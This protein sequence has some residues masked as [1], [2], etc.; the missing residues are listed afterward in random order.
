M[1]KLVGQSE[2][3]IEQAFRVAKACSPCVLLMDEIEKMMG[4]ISSSNSS[5][6]GTLARVF[7]KT[8]EFLAEENDVFVVMTSNDVSQLPPELTRAGRLDAMWYFSLPTE[9]E[10]KEIFRIHL[11]KT[12]KEITDEL[13]EASARASADFTGAEIAETVKIAMR[14]AFKRFKQDGVNAILPEDIE[15]AASEIIPLFKSSEEKIMALE[16]WARGR[17]RSTNHLNTSGVEESSDH[18]LLEDILELKR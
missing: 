2:R 7:G 11:G 10:R 8:L 12:G 4:G 18:Q 14:K 5:D 13:I 16:A 6:S 1:D 17:A 9:E 3:K 15:S